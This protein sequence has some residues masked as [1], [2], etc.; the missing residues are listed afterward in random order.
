MI[1]IPEAILKVKPT[2]TQSGTILSIE[3]RHSKSSR[4][5]NALIFK[6][7]LKEFF[8]LTH[9]NSEKLELC[10]DNKCNSSFEPE[11]TAAQKRSFSLRIFSL[12]VTKSTGNCGCGHI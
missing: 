3:D 10:Q 4:L 8:A 12:N 11:S 6:N 9:S 7:I 2:V 1:N 5:Q